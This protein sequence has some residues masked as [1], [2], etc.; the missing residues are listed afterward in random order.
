M[1][2][3]T[4]RESFYPYRDCP[5]AI[6]GLGNMT[7]EIIEQEKKYFHFVGLLD[8]YRTDGEMYGLPVLSMEDLAALQVTVIIVAARPSSC[9]IIVNRIRDFC[10][11][12]HIRIFDVNGKDLSDNTV[13]ETIDLA[14]GS[15]KKE[16]LQKINEYD[17]VSFDVFDTLLMRKALYPEDVFEIVERK[18]PDQLRSKIRY[19]NERQLAEK[20]LSRNSVPTW[21]EIYRYLGKKNGLSQEETEELKKLEWEM[22]KLLILPRQEMCQV[23]QYALAHKRV[24]LVSDMYFSSGQIQELL[25][26]NGLAGYNKL[27][28]SCEYRR[29]KKNGLF[30]YVLKEVGDSSVLHI[31]DSEEA[32]VESA[33]KYGIEGIQ[34][35]NALEMFEKS[36][37]KGKLDRQDTLEQRIKL[38]MFIARLF[39][40]PFKKESGNGSIKRPEDL[41]Y[42]LFAPV[43]TDF[44]FWLWNKVKENGEETVL[45]GA[46]DGFLIEQLFSK[47][48]EK[49]GRSP[50]SV[51][52]LTSR[53]CAVLSAIYEQKDILQVANVGYSG[54]FHQML[55]TR[56]LIKEDEIAHQKTDIR[57]YVPL[58]LKRAREK[59]KNY[60]KYIKSLQLGSGRKAFFDFVSSGTCQLALEKITGEKMLG[61]YFMR[62]DDG[63]DEKKHLEIRSFYSMGGKDRK[64]KDLYQ[65]YFILEN[66]L[67]SPMPSLQGFD[68]GGKP[69]FLLEDRSEEEITFVE[70]VHSGIKRYFGEYLEICDISGTEDQTT[71]RELSEALLELIHSMPMYSVGLSRMCWSDVFYGRSAMVSEMM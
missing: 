38:G 66:I 71:G 69:E 28:V 68:S 13:A 27:F 65:D 64:S 33:V 14:V 60:L 43:L 12:A 19:A 58:I 5:I 51:Y 1:V 6:Y 10:S 42:L 11:Q 31:G 46:R 54:T 25:E 36:G 70:K 61:Y 2:S 52:F 32:D 63:C 56:F 26:R 57:G 7:K 34:V 24:Y 18:L 37:L 40:S 3:G 59:R 44:T 62:I 49:A 9:R 39:N 50:E 16:L 20:E 30:E 53:I 48:Q 35:P 29:T 67:T 55:K 45:F 17:A 4:F 15:S 22:E 21:E 8:G 47:L 41:G 23:F